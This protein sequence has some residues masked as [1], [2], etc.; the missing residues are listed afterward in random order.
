MAFSSS[1]KLGAA[2]NTAVGRI[3]ERTLGANKKLVNQLNHTDE[4]LFAPKKYYTHFSP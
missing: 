3:K 1:L 2:R 4:S